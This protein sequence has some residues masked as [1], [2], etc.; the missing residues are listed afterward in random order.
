MN[1]FLLAGD[2]FIPEIHLRPPGL[3][4]SAREPFA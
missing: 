1:K 3:A 4:H 2:T